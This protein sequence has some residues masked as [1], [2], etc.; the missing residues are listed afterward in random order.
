MQLKMCKF[1]VQILSQ[2]IPRRC[3]HNPGWRQSYFYIIWQTCLLTQGWRNVS[4][5]NITVLLLVILNAERKECVYFSAFVLSVRAL[6]CIVEKRFVAELAGYLYNVHFLFGLLEIGISS[7]VASSSS[8]TS[9]KS[10]SWVESCGRLP[11]S[12]AR[13]TLS[14]FSTTSNNVWAA[15]HQSQ[16]L[17]TY[18]AK[19]GNSHQNL[20]Y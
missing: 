6:C 7:N 20:T 18:K 14:W 12:L 4:S 9:S 16:V 11:K 3:G 15:K 8:K 13:C 10:K 17:N 19:D 2:R 1:I 5:S